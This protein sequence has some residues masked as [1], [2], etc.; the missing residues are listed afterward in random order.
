[1]ENLK[2]DIWF[3]GGTC[4]GEDWRKELIPYLEKKSTKSFSVTDGSKAPTNIFLEESII[5]SLFLPSTASFTST[6]LPFIS[7][8][9]DNILFSSLPG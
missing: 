7:C 1:M 6:I 4:S 2:K 8:F 9:L 3:L 5:S